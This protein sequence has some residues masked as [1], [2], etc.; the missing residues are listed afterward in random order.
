MA[1]GRVRARSIEITGKGTAADLKEG[2]QV[3][4][5]GE[6]TDG[7]LTARTVRQGNLPTGGFNRSPIATPSTR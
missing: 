4:V 7:S 1:R 2:Q 3:I 6:T 5:S